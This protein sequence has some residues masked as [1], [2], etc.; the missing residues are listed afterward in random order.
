MKK[1]GFR[2]EIYAPDTKAVENMV[3]EKGPN[4]FYENVENREFCCRVRKVEPLERALK[5][6]Q[7][8]ICGL[9]REQAVTRAELNVIGWD[10]ANGLY[11]INPL[12]YWTE[13]QV[14]DYLR[15][16]NVPYNRLHDH[17]YPSVGCA[18][19]TRAIKPGEDAR[20]GRWWWESPEKKECG[21][22]IEI[23]EKRIKRKGN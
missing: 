23:K 13:K 1:Y 4:L 22:H 15:Q 7:A 8:W 5:G 21:L 12:I 11:K 19:C 10:E 17:G 2:Y 16:N 6:K 20:A 18:P 14:W 3:S 9:R